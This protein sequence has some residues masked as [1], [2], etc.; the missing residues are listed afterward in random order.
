MRGSRL[1]KSAA[2]P[3]AVSWT[4][5]GIKSATSFVVGASGTVRTACPP[6]HSCAPRSSVLSFAISSRWR[7][8]M[9][10][11]LPLLWPCYTVLS[12]AT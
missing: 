7:P 3:R 1:P 5:P 2:Q 9:S 10:A 8:L 4:P 6:P 11:A 12:I